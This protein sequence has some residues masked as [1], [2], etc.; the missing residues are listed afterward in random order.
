ML[1]GRLGELLL[2]LLIVLI[3][4]GAG[5]LPRVMQ[6]LGRG[7]KAFRKGMDDGSSEKNSN[8]DRILEVVKQKKDKKPQRNNK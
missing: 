7:M 3:F 2:I 8:D 5:K 6:D 1:S 4:F